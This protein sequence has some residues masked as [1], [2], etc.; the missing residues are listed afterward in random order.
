[1][2]ILISVNREGR[3]VDHGIKRLMILIAALCSYPFVFKLL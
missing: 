3:W 2:R 1:M